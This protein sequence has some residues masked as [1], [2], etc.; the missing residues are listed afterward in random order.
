[1]HEM[2]LMESTLQMVHDLASEQHIKQVTEVCLR[3]GELSGAMP[4]ALQFAF[5]ALQKV[6]SYS[7]FKDAKLTIEWEEAVAECHVCSSSYHPDRRILLCPTCKMPSGKLIQGET[8]QV[9]Y[10]EGE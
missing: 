3:V 9:L 1:M 4:D 6:D 7:L 5:D 2:S 10:F 8:L